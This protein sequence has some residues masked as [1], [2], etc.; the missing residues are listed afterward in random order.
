[1]SALP[2]VLSALGPG[3]AAVWTAD[4]SLHE[5]IRSAL[6][7]LGQRVE[8]TRGTPAGA[9][10]IVA[11][12]PPTGAH[13]AALAAA[14]EVTLLT[15]PGTE[16][17]AQALASPRR[18][19]LLPG[20]PAVA[21]GDAARRRRVIARLL[22]GGTPEE[23][24][25]ALAPLFET[26]EPTLV[27]AAL[28]QAW[29]AGGEPPPPAQAPASSAARVWVNAGR[30]DEVGPHDL[31]GLLVNELRLDR[32]AIGRIELRET[33]SLVEVPAED[34]GRIA[35]ALTGRTLRRRRLIAR[36]DTG[37]PRRPHRGGP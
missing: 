3:T 11:F 28:Y 1:V 23:G 24:L 15:P 6:A 19:L 14:G 36:V 37:A 10:H 8:V 18:P 25:R 2:D 16:R 27:A 4:T 7:G 17:W 21:G 22:E 35:T 31:V 13:F 12:D 34:A 29:R 9:A 20:D 32:A 26:H 33:F 30:K 5:A